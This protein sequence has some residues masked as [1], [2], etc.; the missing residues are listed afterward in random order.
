MLLSGGAEVLGPFGE[1]VLFAAARSDHVGS[2][3]KPNLRAGRHVFCDRFI[4]SSRAYQAQAGNALRHLERAAIDRALPDVTFIFDIPPRLGIR[5]VL[6]RDTSLDRFEQSRVEEQE[7]RRAAFIAIA[8][9]EPQ[10]CVV[11]D[12]EGSIEDVAR[13]VDAALASRLPRLLHPD[14][15]EATA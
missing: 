15:D 9:R 8:A 1:A 2:F 10:R 11:I 13:R 7:R 14:V 12:A 5:R 4:D 3:I 6:E